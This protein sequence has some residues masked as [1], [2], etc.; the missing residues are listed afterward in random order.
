[1]EEKN[2]HTQTRP[3]RPNVQAEP[4][5]E[6]AVSELADSEVENPVYLIRE[7]KVMLEKDVARL[8]EVE[9]RALIRAVRRH[10]ALFPVDFMFKLTAEEYAAV[11][12]QAIVEQNMHRNRSTPYAFTE[13]GVAMTAQILNSARALQVNVAIL[14]DFVRLRRLCGS[15][16]ELAD[17]LDAMDAKYD[18]QFKRIASALEAMQ[19]QVQPPPERRIGFYAH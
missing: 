10:I 15:N 9:T 7:Q 12:K 4:Q 1:M 8:Y 14:R 11:Q 19:S 3:P 17:K 5:Y 2:N 16:L 18:Q 13:G 6:M